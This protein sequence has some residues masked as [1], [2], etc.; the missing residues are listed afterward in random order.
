MIECSPTDL[1]R[2]IH[3]IQHFRMNARLHFSVAI[4]ADVFKLQLSDRYEVTKPFS[5]HLYKY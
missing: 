2:I 5:L 3:E 4:H 1:V